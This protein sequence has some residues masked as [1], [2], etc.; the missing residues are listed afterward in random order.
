ME[1]IVF[2]DELTIHN[3]PDN[4]GALRDAVIRLDEMTVDIRGVRKFDIAALQMLVA[5][6][7][8]CAEKGKK[9]TFMIPDAL[10]HRLQFVGLCI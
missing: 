10:I 9:L 2:R 1:M 4:I 5:L 7:K 6:K 8:E 3:I